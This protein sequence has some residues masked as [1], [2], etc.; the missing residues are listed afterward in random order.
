MK[1]EE[2]LNYPHKIQTVGILLSQVIA[3]DS[4]LTQTDILCPKQHHPLFV[5]FKLE[6]K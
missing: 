4:S 3:L 1:F 2:K 6:I 5:I